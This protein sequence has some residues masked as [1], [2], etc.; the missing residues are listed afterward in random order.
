[1][2]WE[3]LFPARHARRATPVGQTG[4]RQNPV[5]MTKLFYGACKVDQSQ[6]DNKYSAHS[7]SIHPD[8]TRS[9]FSPD[10]A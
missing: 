6:V 3:S 2:Q 1:M 4:P 7:G 8:L 10:G 9:E 5:R